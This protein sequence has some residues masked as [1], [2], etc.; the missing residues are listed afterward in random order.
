MVHGYVP[1]DKVKADWRDHL[2]TQEDW[3]AL[4]RSGVAHVMFNPF[5]SWDEF[6][7][8]LKDK[9]GDNNESD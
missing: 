7:G 1:T 2:K 6:V 8:Y 4:N 3:I 5:P 9:E